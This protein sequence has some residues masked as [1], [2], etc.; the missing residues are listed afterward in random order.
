MPINQPRFNGMSQGFWSLRHQ[1]CEAS[2][3]VTWGFVFVCWFLRIGI[4]WKFITIKRTSIWV[5]NM[6]WQTSPPSRHFLSRWFSFPP[7]KKNGLTGVLTKDSTRK[8]FSGTSG[9]FLGES[10]PNLL[11][12]SSSKAPSEARFVRSAPVWMLQ[13]WDGNFS[14]QKDEWI[15]PLEV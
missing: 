2:T 3:Y 4:P 14:R 7:P 9:K 15:H 12:P 10:P 8:D 6:F 11:G 1:G 5:P 13:A